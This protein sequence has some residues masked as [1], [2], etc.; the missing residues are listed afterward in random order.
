MAS[1]NKRLIFVTMVTKPSPFLLPDICSK[2][3]LK[4]SLREKQLQN[5]K[6]GFVRALETIAAQCTRTS[7]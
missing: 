1:K 7:L 2:I 5:S 6:T 4:N 3:D